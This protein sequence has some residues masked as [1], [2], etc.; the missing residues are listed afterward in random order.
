MEKENYYLFNNKK[1][2][3]RTKK[4]RGSNG[5]LYPK[6]VVSLPIGFDIITKKQKYHDYT[7]DNIDDLLSN[8]EYDR[9]NGYLQ[10]K[11]IPTQITVKQLCEKWLEIVWPSLKRNTQLTYKSILNTRIYP[12][13]ANNKAQESLNYE[14]IQKLVNDLYAKKYAEKSILNVKIVLSDVIDYGIQNK[15]LFSNPTKYIKIPKTQ[16]HNYNIL[17]KEKMQKLL[18]IA[19]KYENGNA[20]AIC[21]LGAMRI[22]ECWGLSISDVDVD[23]CTVFIHQ[24]LQRGG[25]VNRTKNGISRKI[26]LPDAAKPFMKAEQEKRINAQQKAGDKWNNKNSLF[27]TGPNGYPVRTEKLYD[28]FKLITEELGV[29]NIR[30]HDLRHSMATAIVNTSGDIYEAQRYLGHLHINS[31]K[32]YLHSTTESSKKLLD[33]MNK[34]FKQ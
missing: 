33:T 28:E 19:P 2:K 34:L 1:Y 12:Y 30:I 7:A 21:M 15:I 18:K 31:T 8:I 9:G 26:T 13:I 23:N 24:Q 16:K 4:C 10:S 14:C 32:I 11:L 3:I 6:Y 27:F 22:G 5:R 25:I 17:D 20:F 29:D